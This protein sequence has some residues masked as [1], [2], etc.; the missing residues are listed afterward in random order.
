MRAAIPHSNNGRNREADARKRQQRGHDHDHET[1]GDDNARAHSIACL[2]LV[3]FF[4]WFMVPPL[5]DASEMTRLG[6]RL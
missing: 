2:R 6:N 4:I 3:F 1:G 5:T